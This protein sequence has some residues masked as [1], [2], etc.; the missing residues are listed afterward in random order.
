MVNSH[1]KLGAWISRSGGDLGDLGGGRFGAS[2][3]V[4]WVGG[5]WGSKSTENK[6][7]TCTQLAPLNDPPQACPTTLGPASNGR[8]T[9]ATLTLTLPAPLPMFYHSPSSPPQPHPPGP[10][11]PPLTLTKQAPTLTWS[12]LKL[13][14]VMGGRGQPTLGPRVSLEPG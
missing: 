6:G 12:A 13:A 14:R 7:P 9:A 4:R 5:G 10:Q 11:Q 1:H 8:R 3:G 2:G